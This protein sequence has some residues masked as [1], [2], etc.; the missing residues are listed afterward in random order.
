LNGSRRGRLSVCHLSRTFRVI[1]AGFSLF[2]RETTTT[3]TTIET[4][5]T[6]RNEYECFYSKEKM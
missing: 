2:A 5:K 3:T 6:G 1:V 4:A